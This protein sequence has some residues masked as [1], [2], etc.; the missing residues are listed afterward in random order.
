M[1]DD[2]DFVEETSSLDDH[3]GMA[4]Q[5]A[6]EARRQKSAVIKDQSVLRERRAELE[7]F[8][9]AGPAET[10]PDAVAKARYLLTLFAESAADDDERYG[11]LIKALFA[12]FDHLLD[13][14][15]NDNQTGPTG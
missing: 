13:G 10:W 7:K 3:R 14:T 5:R 15:A 1:A 8:L 12:D 4:A 2:H 6:T 11:K 9:F